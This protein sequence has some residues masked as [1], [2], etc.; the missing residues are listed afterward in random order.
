MR[1]DTEAIAQDPSPNGDRPRLQRVSGTAEPDRPAAGRAQPADEPFADEQTADQPA[2]DD[3]PGDA[4]AP[5]DEQPREAVA[6]DVPPGERLM[7][8][9]GSHELAANAEPA[10]HDPAVEAPADDEPASRDEATDLTPG[11]GPVP[12]VAAIWAEGS[13]R[14]FRDRWYEAQLRFVDDPRQAALDTRSLANEAVDA[15]TA[16]LASHR[17]QL[18]SLPTNGDTEQYR[19]VVQRYRTFFERVLTL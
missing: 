1:P 18:N 5:H 11:D 16:T 6:D 7:D 19:V 12:L 14:D 10:H 17:E 3:Q 2:A 9:S 4:V 8:E 13:V 15:L